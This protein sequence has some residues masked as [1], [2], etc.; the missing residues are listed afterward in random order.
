[1]RIAQPAS[2]TSAARVGGYQASRWIMDIKLDIK[3]HAGSWISSLISSITL[4]LMSTGWFISTPDNMLNVR[5]LVLAYTS[6]AAQH[7][8]VQALRK[9]CMMKYSSDKRST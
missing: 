9:A 1:M 7:H 6:L 8:R 4:I 3:H 5:L 2:D